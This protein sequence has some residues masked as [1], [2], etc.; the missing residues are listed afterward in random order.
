MTSGGGTAAVEAGM[1]EPWSHPVEVTE[2]ARAGGS[3]DR[4]DAELI[5]E[6]M[7]V[8]EIFAMIF[9]RHAPAIRLYVAHRL[10]RD[11]ADDLVAEAFLIAFQQRAGYDLARADARPWLYGI[12]TNLIRRHR[13][14]ELGLFRAIA[15]ATADPPAEPIAD[16]VTRRITAQAAR[17]RLARAL[18]RLPVRQRDVLLLVA[19]GLSVEET[20]AALGV[21]AG[22]VSSR[23]ARARRKLRAELG[24]I[25]AIDDIKE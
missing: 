3:A 18:A 24:G 23:L 7:R 10:G 12:T 9:D 20:A 11:I 15:R 2:E 8:P 5:A 13:R 19:S 14:D 21:P 22:T 6:S 16:Q 17:G 1:V 25:S 4:D